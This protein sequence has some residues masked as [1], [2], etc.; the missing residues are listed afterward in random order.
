VDFSLTLLLELAPPGLCT[1]ILAGP[2]GLGG[3]LTT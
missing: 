1:G 2:L 3:Q